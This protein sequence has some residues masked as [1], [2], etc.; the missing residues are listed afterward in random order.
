VASAAPCGF[1]RRHSK[2]SLIKASLYPDQHHASTATIVAWN[3]K[4]CHAAPHTFFYLWL[5][6]AE[7]RSY[8]GLEDAMQPPASVAIPKIGC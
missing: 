3:E 2:T 5:R 8:F 4:P 6:V 1:P 7:T